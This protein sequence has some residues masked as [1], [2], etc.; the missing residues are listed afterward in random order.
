MVA[1]GPR[2]PSPTNSDYPVLGSGMIVA[3][4]E[5][6]EINTHTLTSETYPVP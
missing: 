5:L 3:A 6:Q 4:T 2:I 1:V